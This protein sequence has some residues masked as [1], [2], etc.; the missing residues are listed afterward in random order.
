MIESIKHGAILKSKGSGKRGRKPSQ[1]AE[2]NLPATKYNKQ[3]SKLIAE[4]CYR[5]NR[6]AKEKFF[7]NKVGS[8]IFINAADHLRS[9]IATNP[10]YLKSQPIYLDLINDFLSL[11]VSGLR[12]F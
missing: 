6:K 12:G 9:Y 7:K 1:T 5:F 10:D 8:F 3:F 4:V 11:S 2:A